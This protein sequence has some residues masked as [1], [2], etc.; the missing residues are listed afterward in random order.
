MPNLRGPSR[1]LLPLVHDQRA[2][3]V[4]VTCEM[5]HRAVSLLQVLCIG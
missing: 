5:S 2:G 1:P 4:T 3:Q